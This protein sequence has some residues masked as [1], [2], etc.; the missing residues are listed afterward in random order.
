[1]GEIILYQ[2]KILLKSFIKMPYYKNNPLD[3]F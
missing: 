1:M 3:L 2:I